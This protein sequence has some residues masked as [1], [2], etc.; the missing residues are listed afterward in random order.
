M[1]YDLFMAKYFK[2]CVN[3]SLNILNFIV[4]YISLKYFLVDKII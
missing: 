1:H 3:A 2:M 4:K